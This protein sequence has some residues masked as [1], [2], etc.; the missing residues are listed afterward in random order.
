[1]SNDVT[2][3]PDEK[4]RGKLLSEKLDVR[5]LAR[6]WQLLVKILDESSLALNSK[7]SVEM[8][9]IRVAYASNGPTPDELLKNIMRGD[10]VQSSRPSVD[11][12]SEPEDEKPE[13]NQKKKLVLKAPMI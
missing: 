13:L 10:V 4:S 12:F 1:M 9:L 11:K 5:E 6:I 2:L 8:G 3:S 7:I